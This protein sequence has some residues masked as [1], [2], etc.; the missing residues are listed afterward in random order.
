MQIS[1]RV[2]NSAHGNAVQVATD[3]R[4]QA[5]AIPPKQTGLGSAVNGGELSF[6][7]LATCFCNDL[8]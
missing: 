8:Y 2:T 7:A 5:L 3:G 6:L 4:S 1:A